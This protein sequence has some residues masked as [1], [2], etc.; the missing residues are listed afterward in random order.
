M[1]I[2]AEPTLRAQLSR[3]RS[4]FAPAFVGA[5]FVIVLAAMGWNVKQNAELN[6]QIQAQRYV[7]TVNAYEQGPA[8][9][10]HGTE[11]APGAEGKL[12]LDVDSKVAVLVAVNMP[13]LSEDRVYQVWLTTGDG[14]EV[15]GGV[16]KV[17]AEGNGLV[18]LR[19]PQRLDAYVRVAVTDEPAGGSNAPTTEPVLLAE[20][21]SQ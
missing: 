7:L 19:A 4:W 11:K 10:V 13:D 17:D 14:R 15:G 16:L 3:L 9:D 1:N 5:A 18:L 20:L 6:R 2:G 12:Y 21:T 8:Q